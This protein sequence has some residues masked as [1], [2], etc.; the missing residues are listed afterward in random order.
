MVGTSEEDMAGA[1]N[2]V[3]KLGGGIVLHAGGDMQAELEL[4][5]GGFLSRLSIE[6]VVKRLN[7][8]QGKAE[9]MGFRFPDAALALA[10]LTTPAIPFMRITEDGLMDMKKGLIVPLIIR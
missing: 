3:S 4:S 2:R 9:A 8:L 10:T 5:I 7:T 6:E 1:V